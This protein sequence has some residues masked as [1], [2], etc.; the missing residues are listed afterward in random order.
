[1]RSKKKASVFDLVMFI[2]FMF[3]FAIVFLITYKITISL[4]NNIQQST[5]ISDAGK[6]AVQ[7]VRDS[8]VSRFDAIYLFIFVFMAIA[9]FVAVASLNTH[10]IMFWVSIILIVILGFVAAILANVYN[11]VAATPDLASIS[12]EFKMMPFIMKNYVPVVIIIMMVAL[13][14]AFAKKR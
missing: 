7:N 10:P 1:M 9:I 5:V 6:A 11:D 12:G 13:I 4:N 14:V 3:A 8:F 2:V